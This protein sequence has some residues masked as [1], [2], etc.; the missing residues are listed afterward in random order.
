MRLLQLLNYR[1]NR[2]LERRFPDGLYQRALII[3]IAPMVL[4]QSIM[5]VVILDQYWDNVSRALARSL[6]R[7]VGMMVETYQRS[8]KSPVAVADLRKTARERLAINF[9][10]IKNRTLPQQVE[11]PFFAFFDRKM[12]RYLTRDTKRD[13]WVDSESKNDTIEIQVELKKGEILRFISDA[14]RAQASS[15]PLILLLMIGSSVVL[16]GIAVGF[17]RKQIQPILGLASA[18]KEFGLGRETKEFRPRGAGE[19]REAGEA[20]IEMRRRIARHV[21]QRTAMLAG[22]SHDLRTILTRFKLELAVLGNNA[23]TKS[24]K[25]DVDEMQQMLEDYVAF[26]KGDG[27]EVAT[28]VSTLGV[29]QTIVSNIQRQVHA[30]ASK[31]TINELPMQPVKLKFNGFRRLLSNV[32]G[33]AVR[34]GTHVEI[35]GRIADGR[36]WIFVDDNGPG[37]PEAQREDVFRPF[38]RLDNSRNLDETGTGLGLAIALDIAHAHGG[39]ITL[40]DSNLGGLRVAIKLPV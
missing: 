15:T 5:T 29:V 4:L 22:V 28:E 39:D 34:H 17:L 12:Q 27:G 18:A 9:S 26:V 16:M 30:N 10:V 21:E 14:E 23:K 24:L 1:F 13:F 40:E 36:L 20:F 35:S 31:I 38:V 3:L 8:D 11:P 37:I 33:N 7:Q 19:I 32:I 6:S 2:W 25:G